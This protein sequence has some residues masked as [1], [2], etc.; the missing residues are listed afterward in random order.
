MQRRGR[1]ALA[2][3]LLAGISCAKK[4]ALSDYDRCGLQGME[5]EGVTMTE[6]HGG[7]V[8]WGAG[9][10]MMGSANSRGRDVVCKLPPPGDRDRACEVNAY[11]AKAKFKMKEHRTSS[12]ELEELAKESIALWQRVYRICMAGVEEDGEGQ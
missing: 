9:R 4:L 12:E 1:L 2:L 7:G 10:M 5:L 3:V 6:R 11:R 8:Y